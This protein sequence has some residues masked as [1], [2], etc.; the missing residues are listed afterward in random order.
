MLPKTVL[1]RRK[2]VIKALLVIVLAIICATS[3]F[4]PA[5]AASIRNVYF[6]NGQVVQG[7]L[8]RRESDL[9]GATKEFA[10]GKDKI[11]RLFIIFGDLDAHELGGELKAADGKVVSRVKRQLNAASAAAN[12]SWRFTFQNFNLENL[13]PGEYKFELLVDGQSPGTYAF[14]LR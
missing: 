9:P 5:L 7:Q 4:V 6:S 8:Y 12:L 10:K 1:R 3:A 14:T 11:A 13:E 2:A